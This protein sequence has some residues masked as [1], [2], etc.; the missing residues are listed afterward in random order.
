[1]KYKK[2][3]I[4]LVVVAIVIAAGIWFYRS[5]VASVAVNENDFMEV[6]RVDFP[7]IISS[8]GLLEARSTVPISCP[9]V[10]NERRFKLV[11]VIDEG[12]QVASADTAPAGVGTGR[13]P[14][15]AVC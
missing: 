4:S 13:P 6:K 15:A 3:I 7:Q 8:S 10:G 5:S 12:T 9:Q 2:L 14:T 11:R 1:M